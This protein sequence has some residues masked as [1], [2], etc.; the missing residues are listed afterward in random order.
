MNTIEEQLWNYID[1]NCDAVEALEIESKIASNLQYHAAYQELLAV[2]RE[3]NK[4]DFEE[5]S[6]SFTRNV[7]DK[8]ALELPPVALKTKIDNRIIYSIGV[9]FVLSLLAIFGYALSLSKWDFELPKM[10]FSV[11]PTKIFTPTSMLMFVIFDVAL[12]LIYLD[13]LLRKRSIKKEAK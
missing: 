9:I 12:G 11:N 3:L 2:H 13:N 7:M 8:V 1:G 5:P 10:H 4:F 6:L